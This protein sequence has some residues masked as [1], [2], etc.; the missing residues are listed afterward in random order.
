MLEEAGRALLCAPYFSSVVLAA[1]AVLHSGDD[2]ACKDY[3]PGLASGELRGTLALTED[4][5][6]WDEEAITL[7]RD[8]VG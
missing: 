5:G 2:A 8:P 1:N 7:D 3:L 4:S 6:R